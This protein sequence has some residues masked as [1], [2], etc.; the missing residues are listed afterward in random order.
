MT[1]R[2]Q[3]KV[4]VSLTLAAVPTV[5]RCAR[6]FATIS[7]K[8]WGLG[9]LVET[10]ELLVSE[11][12]TNAVKSTGVLDESPKWS[13]LKDLALIDVRLVLLEDGVIIE[14]VDRDR[15]PPVIRDQ[16]PDA[17][18]GRGMLLV[19]TLSKQWDFFFPTSGG[20]VVWCEIE[21][22]PPIV[23][24]LPKRMR[25][26]TADT[27]RPPA[28]PPDVELLRRVYDGLRRL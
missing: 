19:E 2:R 9:D 16:S 5:V 28:M 18:S 21:L 14:V 1:T 12:V 26:E 13:A 17:E 8:E 24:G 11:L 10:A 7:P 4:I 23:N 6:M 20:K 25:S 22:P 3:P 15:R 27:N